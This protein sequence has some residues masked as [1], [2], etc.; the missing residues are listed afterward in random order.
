MLDSWLI[1]KVERLA[2]E[3]DVRAAIWLLFK[4]ANCTDEIDTNSSALRLV[5]CKAVR[6]WIWSVFIACQ[7]TISSAS[8]CVVLSSATCAA[9]RA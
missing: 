7:S 2:N 1:C 4:A 8:T 3:A 5:I 9:V 6:P